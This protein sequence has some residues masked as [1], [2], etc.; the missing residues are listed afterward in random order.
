MM[1][2]E[3]KAEHLS[4]ELEKK[5]KSHRDKME[6]Y[7]NSLSKKLVSL[8][9]EF[10]QETGNRKQGEQRLKNRFYDELS[11]FKGVIEKERERRVSSQRKIHTMI[12]EI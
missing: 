7:L 12:E 9:K 1:A 10:K 8:Q 6:S 11:E 5:A 2:T 3:E 4:E